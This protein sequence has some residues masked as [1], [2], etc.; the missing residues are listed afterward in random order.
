MKTCTRGNNDRTPLT[1]VSEQTYALQGGP[2]LANEREEVRLVRLW[3]DVNTNNSRTRWNVGGGRADILTRKQ[4][5][6]A[7]KV[8]ENQTQGTCSAIS[9]VA[10]S[11]V[12][13]SAT[14][15]TWS[16]PSYATS[17]SL[18]ASIVLCR[19]ELLVSTSPLTSTAH[20]LS[21]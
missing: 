14:S 1:A 18:P 2:S 11:H 12:G 9:E 21:F 17:G 15:T 3:M 13:I 16:S 8:T 4:R 19:R 20:P 6:T 7:T 5:E 10:L